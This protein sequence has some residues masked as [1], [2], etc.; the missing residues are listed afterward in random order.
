[1][2]GGLGLELLMV[3][4]ALFL[5]ICVLASKVSSKLGIPSLVFFIGIGMLAG[6]EGFGGIHF[7]DVG[8]TKGV[9]AIALAFILFAGGLDTDLEQLKP[10]LW[11]GL[12]LSTLGTAVTAAL[13]GLFAH[14]FL[15]FSWLEGMLLGAVV[16]PTD[17]A[18]VFGVLRASRLRLKHRIA[19]MLEFE[20]GMNDPI[21]IFL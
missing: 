9:G 2:G 21:A 6:S 13:V 14:Y 17:A 4:V 5:L 19:P 12:S 7:D 16:S 3:L 18:A 20:S 15:G 8:L 11:R 10:S 1:M